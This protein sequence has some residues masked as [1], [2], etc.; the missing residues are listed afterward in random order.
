MLHIELI[1]PSRATGRAGKLITR[2]DVH[3]GLDVMARE[4]PK[5]FA[6]V[7]ADD[8]DADTADAFVQCAVFGKV[9]YG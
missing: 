3:H 1:A 2:D 7:M 4:Y 8:G 6:K 5:H 9:I